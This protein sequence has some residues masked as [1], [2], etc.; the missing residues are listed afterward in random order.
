MLALSVPNSRRWFWHRPAP[1]SNIPNLTGPD[2]L[3]VRGEERVEGAGENRD[4]SKA[5]GGT[6]PA[7]TLEWDTDTQNSGDK[8]SVAKTPTN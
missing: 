1:D 7:V 5:K 4:L 3:G 2:A 8:V 6:F